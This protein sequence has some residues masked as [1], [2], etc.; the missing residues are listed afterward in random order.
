MTKVDY[1]IGNN[2][3]SK[4]D[5]LIF[6][7]SGKYL[8]TIKT[9]KTKEGCWEYSRG[10]VTRVSD[11]KEICDIKRNYHNFAYSFIIK[12]NQEWLIAGRSYLAQTIVNLET[13]EEFDNTALNGSGY[14]FCWIKSQLNK[15]EDVLIVKGCIWAAPYETRFFDFSDPSKGWSELTIKDG[16][17]LYIP[18]DEHKEDLLHDDGSITVFSTKR[19]F[20][21]TDKSE[22]DLDYESISDVDFDD[23]SNWTVVIRESWKLKRKENEMIVENYFI[24][25]SERRERERRVI[26]QKVFNDKIAKFKK[27]D[28]LYL[29]YAEL[30]NDS[31]LTP[32]NYESHG[33]TYPGWCPKWFGKETR[34]CRRINDRN[35]SNNTWTVDL[36]WAIDTG[37]IKLQI[38]KDGN[39]DHDKWFEHSVKGMIQ[40]FNYAF[41]LITK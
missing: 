33:F 18:A 9:Y 3:D 37:P 12:N 27:E 20:Q 31:R 30:I 11:N 38:Y 7:P 6:S 35:K 4:N 13:G 34:W 29:K 17:K 16:E 5:K 15:A 28:P 23:D 8:L 10:I 22:D 40:A 25:D 26:D 32:N 21:D 41:E 39:T 1:F 2:T 24:S 36:E 14:S 19:F